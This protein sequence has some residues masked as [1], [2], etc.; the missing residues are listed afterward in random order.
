MVVSGPLLA[1]GAD[2][3]HHSILAQSLG[4][5]RIIQISRLDVVFI[6]IDGGLPLQR[7]SDPATRLRVRKLHLAID[8]RVVNVIARASSTRAADT[9]D[10]FPQPDRLTDLRSISILHVSIEAVSAPMVF[11]D[12]RVAKIFIET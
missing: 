7:N 9:A 11:H 12:D 4:V 6:R 3:A 1:L 10:G 2:G 5:R 8:Q